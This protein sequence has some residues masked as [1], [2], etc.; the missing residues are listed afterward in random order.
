MKRLF[1]FLL[2][3]VM[4]FTVVSCMRQPRVE[5]VTPVAESS[6]TTQEEPSEADSRIDSLPGADWNGRGFRIA[7]D[8]PSLIIPTDTIS[9]VGK[10]IYERNCAVEKKFNVKIVYLL[11]GESGQSSVT[12]QIRAHA[13]AGEDYCDLAVVS[14]SACQQLVMDN[15]LLNA[16][17]IPYVSGSG[18][19]VFSSATN[20]MTIGS[21][22]YGFCGD[23]CYSGDS[24]YVLFFNKML[25]ASTGLPDLYQLVRDHSWDQQYFNLYT[26]EAFSLGKINGAKIYGFASTD[27]AESLLQAFW[28]ASD[29]KYVD[30]PYGGVPT[31]AYDSSAIRDGF[32]K[33]T[34]SILKGNIAYQNNKS[35]ALEAF[36]NGEIL[37][38]A[39]PINTIEEVKN[40]SV[41][42]GLIPIPEYDINQETH[43]TYQKLEYQVACF[44]KGIES[45][46]LS[47]QITQALFAASEGMSR[48]LTLTKYLNLYLRSSQDGEMLKLCVREPYFDPTEF[49]GKIHTEYGASTQTLIQRVVFSDGNYNQLYK[50]YSLMFSK[51][52]N[53][54]VLTSM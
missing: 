4:L 15:C 50:Q 28:A 16:A 36:N 35:A 8:D 3:L 53:E 29:L 43:K 34:K 32:I 19:G 49:F 44:P 38:L 14:V 17:S 24:L 39:A 20:A 6:E 2:I 42:W 45:I 26:Q 27:P 41:D 7:T 54:K 40:S 25:A 5:D 22:T 46:D 31:L 1:A 11:S 48:D 47:G 10:K 33:Q 9:Y 18:S 30:N 52:V 23:F 12:E 51:F 13:L 37:F 21:V